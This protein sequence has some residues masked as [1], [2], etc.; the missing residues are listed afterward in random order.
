MNRYILQNKV[1]AARAGG[2]SMT[3]QRLAQLFCLVYTYGRNLNF[4]YN[5]LSYYI[6]TYGYQSLSFELPFR[7][8]AAPKTATNV[9]D[10]EIYGFD[11]FSLF[12]LTYDMDTPAITLEELNNAFQFDNVH[13][14]DLVTVFEQNTT[15]QDHPV[16]RSLV[17]EVW[18]F[19]TYNSINWVNIGDVLF[20]EPD[21]R[22]DYDKA[23]ALQQYVSGGTGDNFA[24]LNR[25]I[26]NKLL[27][28]KE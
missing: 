18:R 8:L 28:S 1:Q 7:L 23:R 20:I 13:A 21:I 6:Y 19:E 5:S 16:N 12:Q 25:E 24:I 27:N 22:L 3:I 10:C 26:F 4:N 2:Y 17:K 9:N 15:L 14:G 11:D